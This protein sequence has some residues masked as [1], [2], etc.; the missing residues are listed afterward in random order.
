[1]LPREEA[2]N[3]IMTGSHWLATVAGWYAA[4]NTAIDSSRHD[5]CIA[6]SANLTRRFGRAQSCCR[7]ADWLYKCCP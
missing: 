7:Q 6:A 4:C 2:G 5:A 1:M 3:S